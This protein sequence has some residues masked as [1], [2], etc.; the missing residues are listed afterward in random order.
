MKKFI[1]ITKEVSVLDDI[2]CNKCGE[3]CMRGHKDYKAHVCEKCLAKFF[4]ELKI[5]PEIKEVH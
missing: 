1:T 3:S 4:S 5:E 2:L